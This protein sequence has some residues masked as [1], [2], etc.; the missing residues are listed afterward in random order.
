MDGR[1]K[2]GLMDG[3]WRKETRNK[4][5]EQIERKHKTNKCVEQKSEIQSNLNGLEGW[6]D[7]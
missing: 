5:P 4:M 7:V 2:G 6:M 3:F 1:A